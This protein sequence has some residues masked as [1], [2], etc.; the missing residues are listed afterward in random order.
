MHQPHSHTHKEL[1]GKL[2]QALEAFDNHRVAFA[3][4]A[5]VT[6]DIDE[7]D[8]A[9]TDEYLDLIHECIQ[10]AQRN[11]LENFRP[12]SPPKSTKHKLTK[13]LPM[14]AFEVQHEAY[15]FQLYFK[16]CLSV[17]AKIS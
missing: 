12:P 7:L 1:A 4:P 13:N 16:F 3:E 11:P 9:D 6:A 17:R 10:L 5:H 15:S 2:R 8:L 14:W